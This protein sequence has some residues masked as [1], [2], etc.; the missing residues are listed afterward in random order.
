VAQ[1]ARR[2]QSRGESRRRGRRD[3]VLLYYLWLPLLLFVATLFGKALPR[4]RLESEGLYIEDDDGKQP[5]YWT[6]IGPARFDWALKRIRWRT[7]EQE[8]MLSASGQD[9]DRATAPMRFLDASLYFADPETEGAA[10]AERMNAW[11][12]RARH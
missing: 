4:L 11:R 3:H 1:F 10:F 8:R 12:E 9:P 2:P 7:A 6:N 5:H